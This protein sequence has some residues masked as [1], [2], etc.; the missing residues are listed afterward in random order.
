MIRGVFD[1][2]NASGGSD[3]ERFVPSF[4]LFVAAFGVGLVALTAWLVLRGAFVASFLATLV[5]LRGPSDLAAERDLL[6]L[7]AATAGLLLAVTAWLP[8]A[9]T[10]YKITRSDRLERARFNRPV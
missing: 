2:L 1:F 3:K 8:Q 7:A 6:G 10:Y 9:L 4:Y 5:A